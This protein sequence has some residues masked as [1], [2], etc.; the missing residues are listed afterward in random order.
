MGTK[1]NVD[2]GSDIGKKLWDIH[3]KDEYTHV[4]NYKEAICINCFRKDNIKG[5]SPLGGG[6]STGN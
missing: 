2:P 5:T 4:D 6:P 3:Q 1:L